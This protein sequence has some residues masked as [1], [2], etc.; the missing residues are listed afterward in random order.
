[1]NKPE[2]VSSPIYA[3]FPSEVEVSILINFEPTNN[4]NTIEAVTIGP[5]PK[6]IRLPK[7]APKIIA[8]NSNLLNAL[9][10]NFTKGMLDNIKKQARMTK[11]HFSLILKLSFFSV[12]FFTSGK[13]NK[14]SLS[15]N[16]IFFS[17]MFCITRFYFICFIF[18]RI[19]ALM[20]L[21]FLY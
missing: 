12:G 6:D 4:C 14:I 17:Y 2:R 9:S 5:I 8:K 1:M 18:S 16:G 15:A 3:F 21:N 20:N 19:S 11:V 10:S 13:F 7:L